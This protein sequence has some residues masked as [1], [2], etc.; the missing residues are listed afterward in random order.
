MESKPETID[1]FIAS[2]PSQIQDILQEVRKTIQLAAPN[3]V[4]CINYGIPTFKLNGNLVHFSGFKNHIGF[5]PGASGIT[6]FA[7]QLSD[8]KS[9]KGSVQF[10]LNQ[11]IPYDLIK[12]IVQFR[13]K[14]NTT[15]KSTKKK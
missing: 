2:Y 6:H 8:Y 9:A 15:S 1:A 14:E 12:T 4:E 7:D 3:A 10:P 5:Y 13:V 11:P